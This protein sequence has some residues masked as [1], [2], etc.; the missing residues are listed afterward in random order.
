[1]TRF[2]S[3]AALVILLAA[4]P[5]WAASP[6]SRQERASQL[7][8]MA[9]AQWKR[10]EHDAAIDSWKSALKLWKGGKVAFNLALALTE[11]E[12]FEEALDVLRTARKYTIPREHR[13]RYNELEERIHAGL[14]ITHAELVLIVRPAEAA[15]R[16]DGKSWFRPHHTFTRDARSAIIVTMPGYQTATR[17][18]RHAPGSKHT[19]EVDLEPEKFGTLIIRAEPHGAT[20]K[21]RGRVVGTTPI[22]PLTPL[23]PGDYPVE[24]SAAGHETARRIIEVKAGRH[25]RWILALT[26]VPVV[27]TPGPKPAPVVA[28][29]PEPR[30]P[31][32]AEDGRAGRIAGWVLAGVG[33]A[34]VATSVALLGASDDIRDHEGADAAYRARMAGWSMLGVGVAAGGTGGLLLWQF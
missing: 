22:E 33:I 7:D 28:P 34:A 15:V 1:M 23:G 11:R 18:W 26:K 32:P 10:G 21:V 5:L 20:V 29:I 13:H 14:R 8:A 24:I 25:H 4:E 2:G 19:M 6:P 17:L 31:T 27:P 3:V 30:P 9:R 16:R 12:R